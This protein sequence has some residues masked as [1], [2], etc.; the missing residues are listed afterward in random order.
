MVLSVIK[1]LEVCRASPSIFS[2]M[3]S[4]SPP[5]SPWSSFY[6][7]WVRRGL[8][9]DSSDHSTHNHPAFD[10]IRHIMEPSDI[11]RHPPTYSSEPPPTYR[12]I[13]SPPT[14]P[15]APSPE[16]LNE[17]FRYSYLRKRWGGLISLPRTKI[18]SL[19]FTI[20]IKDSASGYSTL[21]TCRWRL[22]SLGKY[23]KDWKLQ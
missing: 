15:N 22:R 9:G 8:L 18:T 19:S 3:V 23:A 10:L 16:Y 6:K 2:G 13:T 4:P 12:E 7:R 1:A 5:I 14:Y 11:K 17:M 21:V 20:K